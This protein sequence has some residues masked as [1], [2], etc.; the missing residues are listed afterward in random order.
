MRRSRIT[1][2]FVALVASAFAASEG[3]AQD[4]RF[5]VRPA[6][7]ATGSLDAVTVADIDGDGDSDVVATDT[8]TG[9][10]VWIENDSDVDPAFPIEHVIASGVIAPGEVAAADL[11][12]DG[13][14]DVAAAGSAATAD[15]LWFE[16]LGGVPPKFMARTLG[17]RPNLN[18]SGIV[19]S[20][21]VADLHGD[22]SLDLVCGFELPNA[23]ASGHVTVYL[24]N[25]A[26]PA[27]FIRFQL[28]SP[29]ALLSEVTGVAVA[30]ISGDGALESW[31]VHATQRPGATRTRL[32]RGATQAS[33]A[34]ALCL[35]SSQANSESLRPWRLHSFPPTLCRTSPLQRKAPAES[36]CSRTT[37]P[38]PGRS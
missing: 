2:H 26:S 32:F 1:G 6:L 33:A 9:R 29:A 8:A 15:L 17:P 34:P 37:R 30:D 38:R 10:I 12:G 3:S 4:A 18:T 16:N 25:G 23:A 24:N 19:R 27:G 28:P 20:V 11:D 13:D 5:D 36:S 31:R 35:Q 7:A 22:G 14:V 21:T